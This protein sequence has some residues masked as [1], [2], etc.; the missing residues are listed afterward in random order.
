MYCS[1]EYTTKICIGII[2]INAIRRAKQNSL[3][4][5]PCQT[6][7]RFNTLKLLRQSGSKRSQYALAQYLVLCFV[8]V[9]V[10]ES[11]TTVAP[12]IGQVCLLIQL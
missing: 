6:S 3:T 12:K 11:T 8:V 4:D 2:Y 10:T 1:S 5:K 7:G 9:V